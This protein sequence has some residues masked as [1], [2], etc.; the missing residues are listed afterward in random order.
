M[1][2]MLKFGETELKP[3]R[4]TGDMFLALIESAP[5]D[6]L[7]YAEL[8]DGVLVDMTPANSRHGQ[9]HAD[10]VSAVLT[11]LPEGYNAFID[12]ILRLDPYSL[13]GPD[14]AVLRKGDIPEDSPPER[15]LFCIE[16]ADTSLSHDLHRKAELCGIGGVPDYWVVDLNNRK[17]H[18]HRDPGPDGYRS[19]SAQGW[20]V[21]ASP[22]FA[23][24][25]TLDLA[26]ILKDIP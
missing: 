2:A 11:A 17:L 21:P 18:I 19:V 26:A 16:V 20:E 14:I 7:K 6:E 1:A 5:M 24:G 4:I 3:A 10:I 9:A 15:F 23:P 12:P 25:L 8:I 22:L 13:V